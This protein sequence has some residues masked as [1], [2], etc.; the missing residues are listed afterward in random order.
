MIGQL[1]RRVQIQVLSTT[2]DAYGGDVET[3][4]T[5]RTES[6]KYNPGSG[7]ERRIALQEQSELAATFTFHYSTLTKSMTPQS[8][9]IVFDGGEWD[10]HSVVET[11]RGRWIEVVAKRRMA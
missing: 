2:K 5:V 7:T 3:W 4:T 1:D 9:R 11:M 8:H 6:A 10:I